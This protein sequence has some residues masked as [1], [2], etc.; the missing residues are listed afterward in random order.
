MNTLAPPQVSVVMPMRNAQ[1]YVQAA[2]DSVLQ[3]HGVPLELVV[4]DD[5]ST[6]GS[7]ELVQAVADARVRLIDGPRRGIAA[8]MNAG[9]AAARGE[10][11]MRCDAD[12]LYPEGRI[13]SQAAWL[14]SRPA[15]VA[16]CGPFSSI[17]ARGQLV[18]RLWR[19]DLQAADDIAGELRAGTT[20]THLCCYAMRRAALV[21][22]GLAFREF[23][24]TAEDV[25]F[26]LRLGHLGPVGFIARGSYLY[27]LHEASVTHSQREVRRVFFE[28]AAR[29]FAQQ[30]AERGSDALMDG[31]PPAP[32]EGDGSRPSAA[33]RQIQG[34]LIGGA[35][36]ALARGQRREAMRT[37]WRAVATRP[38]VPA[39]WLHLLKIAVRS[40][41]PR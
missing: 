17:D 25:D 7:R 24:E 26:A 5:G 34:M 6:D 16:V 19:D 3:E 33:A 37:A 36:R 41:V 22:A 2:V 31:Q 18:A 4:V 40:V 29:E 11:V 14:A 1:A 15:H 38:Q 10:L 39:P 32:P 28:N 35:W 13:A 30:R 9:F 21:D 8:C 27:R 20:R 23:F 12:D